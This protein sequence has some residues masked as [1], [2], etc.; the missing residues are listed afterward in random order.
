MRVAIAR[1]EA[2][3]RQHVERT[4]EF[5]RRFEALDRTVRGNGDADKPGLTTRVYQLEQTA[6]TRLR[7]MSAVWVIIAGLTV[8]VV[9]P[10]VE[11]CTRAHAKADASEVTR[12]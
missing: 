2:A 10:I 3:Q 11:S 5:L 12:P 1:I 4:E 7:Q 9:A 6:L 8:A